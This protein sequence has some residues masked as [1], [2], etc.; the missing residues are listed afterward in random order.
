MILIAHNNHTVH[1]IFV[2]SEEI[3]AAA[4]IVLHI[5]KLLMITNMTFR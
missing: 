5:N 1:F 4:N 2:H 3:T